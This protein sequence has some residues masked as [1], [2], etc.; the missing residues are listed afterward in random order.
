MQ[1]FFLIAAG[2][3]LVCQGIVVQAVFAGRAPAS[4]SRPS[5]RWAEVAWVLIPALVLVT[6][7]AVTWL[8]VVEPV[9][10]VPTP[11]VPA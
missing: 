1:T 3:A 2:V 5:A 11:G 10:V 7:L 6:V 9:A 8:R 4:S